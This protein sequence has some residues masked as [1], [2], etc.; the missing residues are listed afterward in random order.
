MHEYDFLH[1]IFSMNLA[2][3]FL[4]SQNRQR[5][6][7]AGIINAIPH[8]FLYFADLF[9]IPAGPPSLPGY[10]Q[11]IR[12]QELVQINFLSFLVKLRQVGRNG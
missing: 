1:M 6:M 4:S 12:Q 10:D 9:A 7:K 8:L 2:L 5:K 11:I 3:R